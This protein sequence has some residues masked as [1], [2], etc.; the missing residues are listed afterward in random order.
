MTNKIPCSA[1]ILTFNSEKTLEK[2]L[3]SLKNF[4]EIIICDGGSTDETLKIAKKHNCKIIQQD[5]KFKNPDN[6]IKDFSGVRNQTLEAATYDWF[7][8]FDSDE[9]LSEELV[10]EI[11]DTID[12]QRSGAARKTTNKPFRHRRNTIKTPETLVFDMPRK[13]I[14]NGKIIDCA[15]TYPNY[16][17]R[18]F[19]KKAV[20]KFRKQVHESIEIK[21]GYEIGKLK[22]FEY[23][24]IEGNSR[25]LMKKWN[26]YIQ[27]E[28]ERHGKISFKT[29]IKVII[30]HIKA[31]GGQLLRHIKILF[32]CKGRRMPFSLE[33]LRHWYNIKVILLFTKKFFIKK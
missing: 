18:L 15:T 28:A 8:Y 5:K 33:M 26:S 2:A 6:T 21:E 4:A 1:G 3:N 10:E 17:T 27:I 23:V 20:K 29:L 22:N 11:G 14:I 31:S 19:N 24:K 25:E 12:A 13:Y 30:F 7:L 9:Y 32:S 16:S